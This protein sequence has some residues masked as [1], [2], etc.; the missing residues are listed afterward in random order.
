MNGIL[1]HAAGMRIAPGKSPQN[2]WLD[3][4]VL[5]DVTIMAGGTRVAR[6]PGSWSR[7]CP[8]EQMIVIRF[9]HPTTVSRLRLVVCEIERSCTQTLAIWASSHRGERH[10]EVLRQ[11]FDFSPS[12][13]R[14]HVEEFAVQLEDVTVLQVRIVP[15]T[16]GPRAVARLSELH[17]AA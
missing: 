3:L 6:S 16:D 11:Q 15:S 14:E 2:R 10:R 7:D 12:G 8:G 9:R 1:G 13:A 17:V 4:D 5:A